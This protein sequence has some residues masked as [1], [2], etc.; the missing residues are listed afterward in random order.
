[1]AR[2]EY[3]KHRLSNWALWKDRESRGGLGFSSQAAFLRQHSGDGYREAQVPILDEDASITDL[4]VESLKMTRQ[5][6]YETIRLHYIGHPHP[7]TVHGVAVHCR[8]TPAA[9]HMRLEQADRAIA[10]WLQERTERMQPG[11]RVQQKQFRTV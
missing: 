7:L 5:T 6:L 10:L 3:I 4:A 1:M 9:V 8:V 11:A 2:I